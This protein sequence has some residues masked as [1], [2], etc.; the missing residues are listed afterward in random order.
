MLMTRRLYRS[1]TDTILGGVASGLAQY[2]N[3]DPALVRIAWAIL[4]P[5]TGGAMFLAYIVAWIVVPEEPYPGAAAGAP[6]PSSM[7]STASATPAGTESATADAGEP[8]TDP[9]TGAPIQPMADTGSSWTPPPPVGRAT[10]RGGA[11]IIVGVGLVLLGLWFL[12]REYLPDFN[13]NFVWPLFIV[14]IGVLV[15]VTATRRREG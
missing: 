6:A 12:L 7:A 15:L 4:V 11:G 14:G 13:W 10:G 2:L 9:V 5:L 3:T 8:A 1:R